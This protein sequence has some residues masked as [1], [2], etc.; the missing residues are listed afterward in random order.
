MKR[1][2]FT[3][4]ELLVVIAIIAILASMLLPALTSARNIAKR[5]QCA[6]N[7]KQIGSGMFMYLNDYNDVFPRQYD[8][9][10]WWF[11]NVDGTPSLYA[12]HETASG[13]INNPKIWECP[14]D[15]KAWTGYHCNMLSYGINYR[16]LGRSSPVVTT[17]LTQIINPSQTIMIA[18][19]KTTKATTKTRCIIEPTANWTANVSTRH[20]TGS[21][22]VFI[23]GHTQWNKFLDIDTSDW[24][25][26]TD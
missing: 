14:S 6:G 18:D 2:A 23:D 8:G 17:K 12:N 24:W 4:I 3:L 25:D 10:Y 5:S 11:E 26:I 19:S 21:N 20:S 16:H 22:M 1:H 7:L 13:Y 9:E 15:D